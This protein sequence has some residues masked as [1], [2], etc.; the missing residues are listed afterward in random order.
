MWHKEDDTCADAFCSCRGELYYIE[1]GVIRTMFGSGTPDKDAVEWMAE[2]GII[3]TDSPDK[4]Y[5][6]K[7][8]IRMSLEIGTRVHFYV[9]YDSSR[10]WEHL[11]T[12][13]G[14]NLRTFT[15]PVR[16]RRCDHLRIRIVGKGEAK[17]Y[18]IAKTIEEG[19]D[20]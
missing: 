15:I 17:I 1:N 8:N 5:I 3:G 4:K 18:S 2:T 19:S 11:F 9:Q 6:S 16:P 12:T 10:Q 20:A 13:T 14:I 7:L